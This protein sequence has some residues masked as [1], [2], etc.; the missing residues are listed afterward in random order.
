[1]AWI[2][3]EFNERSTLWIITV[4]GFSGLFF[5]LKIKENEPDSSSRKGKLFSIRN[6]YDWNLIFIVRQGRGNYFL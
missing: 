3:L 2:E 6:S 1:V 4:L 5:A